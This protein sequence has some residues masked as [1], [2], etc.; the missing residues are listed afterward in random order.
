MVFCFY[1]ALFVAQL[2][3]LASRPEVQKNVMYFLESSIYSYGLS[4]LLGFA[5]N[6]R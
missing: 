6:L 5:P 3:R 2:V 1:V 4:I